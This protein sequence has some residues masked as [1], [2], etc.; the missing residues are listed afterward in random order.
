MR[1]RGSSPPS[2]LAASSD[3]RIRAGPR[4]KRGGAF[5]PRRL[6]GEIAFSAIYIALRHRHQCDTATVLEPC[7]DVATLPFGVEALPPNVPPADAVPPCALFV[8]LAV[9]LVAPPA[10][11]ALPEPPA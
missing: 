3:T 7:P 5:R 8:E 4:N 11:V 10:P 6:R 9:L 2:D 1:P